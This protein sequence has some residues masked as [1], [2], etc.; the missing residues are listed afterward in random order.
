MGIENETF[1]GHQ[2]D[3]VA[4]QFADADFRSL[5]IAEYAHRPAEL[6][7]R[8]A[9]AG[10]PGLVIIDAAVREIHP[11]NVDAGQHHAFE[12]FR[13]RGGGAERGNNLGVA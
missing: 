11:D 7:R 2:R 9:D 13:R 12:N 10:G 8:R 1:T 4:I 5:Q 3:L 6:G